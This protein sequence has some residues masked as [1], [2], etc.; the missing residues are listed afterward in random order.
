MGRRVERHQQI[1]EEMA[2][3]LPALD[4]ANAERVAED[5][6]AGR[7][8]ALSLQVDDAFSVDLIATGNAAE[9]NRLS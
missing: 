7:V 6:G 9:V 4:A 8:N 5:P 3:P 2:S 1:P